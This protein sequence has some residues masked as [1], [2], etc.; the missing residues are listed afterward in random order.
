MA[1]NPFGAWINPIL[2]AESEHCGQILCPSEELSHKIRYSVFMNLIKNEK[3]NIYNLCD[4]K[5]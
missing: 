5:V 3:S 2:C 4:K 1:N